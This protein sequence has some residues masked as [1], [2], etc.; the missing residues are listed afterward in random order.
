PGQGRVVLSVYDIRGE[1][2]RDLYIGK[3]SPGIYTI[4]WN[5]LNNAGAPVSPGI[6]FCRLQTDGYSETIKMFLLK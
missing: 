6:Y 3:Q 5:G 4:E 2:V 1:L